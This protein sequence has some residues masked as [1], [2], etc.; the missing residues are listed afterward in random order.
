[1]NFSTQARIALWNRGGFF[2]HP[3]TKICRVQ[4]KMTTNN[5]NSNK[6]TADNN[7][8]IYDSFSKYYQCHFTHFQH[9]AAHSSLTVVL[10]ALSLLPTSSCPPEHMWPISIKA[11]R[12]Y[13]TIPLVLPCLLERLD[14]KTNTT[15]QTVLSFCNHPCKR[16]NSK[17]KTTSQTVLQWPMQNRWVLSPLVLFIRERAWWRHY[18]LFEMASFSVRAVASSSRCLSCQDQLWMVSCG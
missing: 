18:S 13:K 3:F 2:F 11:K 15:W 6:Q 9:P 8:L 16:D 4:E 12:V 10:P 7:K 5:C 14:N 17:T 1:M